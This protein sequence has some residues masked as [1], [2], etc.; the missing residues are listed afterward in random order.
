MGA[1]ETWSVDGGM[2]VSVGR[3]MWHKCKDLIAGVQADWKQTVELCRHSSSVC[4]DSSTD[5]VTP[6]QGT[7]QSYLVRA[8]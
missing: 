1:G 3:A 8:L 2:G 6:K 5:V 4:S 7:E